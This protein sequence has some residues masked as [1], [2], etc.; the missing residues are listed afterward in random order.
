MALTELQIPTKLQFYSS[1][2][3]AATHMDK[4]I[5]QWKSI[6]EFIDPAR[7]GVADLDA[8][9]VASGQVRT[10]LANF[11]IV[12]NEMISLYEGNSV[13]PTNIPA[14]VIDNIRRMEA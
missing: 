6:A 2:Q 13:T 8:M 1:I 14:D 5:S 3:G 11:R 10:D 4:L 12:L 9:G 7:M